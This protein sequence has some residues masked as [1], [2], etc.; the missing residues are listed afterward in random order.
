M[1]GT[2]S[3]DYYY[4]S[5]NH[6]TNLTETTTGASVVGMGGYRYDGHGRR[7]QSWTAGG[8]RIL[9]FYGQDGVLRRQN[10]ERQGKTI[11]Y[12]SLNYGYR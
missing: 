8:S 11:K 2:T 1:T 5:A 6:L 7:V 9:S 10:N 3:Y 4:D 12:V